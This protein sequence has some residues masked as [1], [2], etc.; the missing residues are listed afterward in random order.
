[1]D[2]PKDVVRF[3]DGKFDLPVK[4]GFGQGNLQERCSAH[5]VLENAPPHLISYYERTPTFSFNVLTLHQ[6]VSY[7]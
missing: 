7:D 4:S 6:K 1:M 3:P 5:D 2:P